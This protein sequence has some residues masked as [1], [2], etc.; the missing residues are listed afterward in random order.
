[1]GT[2]PPPSSNYQMVS[3]KDSLVIIGG[4]TNFDR[5]YRLRVLGGPLSWETIACPG[6]RPSNRRDFSCTLVPFGQ[7]EEDDDMAAILFGGAR[8]NTLYNDVFSLDLRAWETGGGC[9][10]G[11]GL[12][13]LG[14]AEALPCWVAG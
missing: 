1:M 14:I 9:S 8:G 13:R 4:D 10:G 6:T 12:S 11:C 5:L 7:A 2:P 3:L